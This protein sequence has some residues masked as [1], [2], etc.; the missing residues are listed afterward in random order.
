MAIRVFSDIGPFGNNI[1]LV[2]DEASKET[3]LV[4]TSLS[5]EVAWDVI[6]QEGLSLTCILNTHGHLDHLI[7]NAYF[8]GKAPTA[9]LLL[10]RDDLFLLEGMV[11]DAKRWGV[12]IAPSPAP[13]RFIVGGDLITLG[14]T[15]L[16]V[17]HTP[18]HTPGSVSVYGD[19]WVIAGDALFRG[20]IGRCDLPGGDMP[21][22]LT[23]IREQLL[24]LPQETVVH[25]GH[26]PS[27]TIGDER[28]DN[29]YLQESF[30]KRMGLA[31]LTQQE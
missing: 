18:G 3:L 5:S 11:E 1:Y 23:S 13:D 15:L 29:P 14:K 6:Q 31:Y 28:A 4:D 26:G 16:S 20:S 22:L 17:L 2:W 21:Q 9:G 8:K 24:V 27:T 12:N 25:P 19:G 30:F 7:N 10:H